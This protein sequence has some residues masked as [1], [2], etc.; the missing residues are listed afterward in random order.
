MLCNKHEVGVIYVSLS[1]DK[2]ERKNGE[3]EETRMATH[4]DGPTEVRST[5][6]EW[7]EM[8]HSFLKLKLHLTSGCDSPLVP[9]PSS[10][11]HSFHLVTE[12]HRIGLACF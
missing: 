6:S 9:Q 4:K 10:V 11:C 3:K 12:H 5:G 2:S 7:R 8:A 1:R